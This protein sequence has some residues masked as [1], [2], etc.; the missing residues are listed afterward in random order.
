MYRFTRRIHFEYS[1]FLDCFTYEYWHLSAISQSL[2]I[3]QSVTE[4]H[5]GTTKAFSTNLSLGF[6]SVSL[7]HLCDEGLG[8]LCW[9]LVGSVT[10]A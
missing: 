9:G 4:A 7:C 10:S 1:L 5:Q 6:T 2:F 3:S 8:A